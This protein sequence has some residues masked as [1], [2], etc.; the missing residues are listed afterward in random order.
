MAND[1]VGGDKCISSGERLVRDLA[2]SL[3]PLRLVDSLSVC[4]V[5]AAERKV[6]EAQ[7]GANLLQ[8]LGITAV[9]NPPYGVP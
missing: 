5:E 9:P 3:T 8:V 6:G 4:E 1:K 7:N 2:N